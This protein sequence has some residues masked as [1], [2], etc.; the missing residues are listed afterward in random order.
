M[1]GETLCLPP[2]RELSAARQRNLIR[3]LVRQRGWCTPPE[4]RLSAGLRQLLAARAD[5]HPVLAWSNH[6]IRRFR[7]RLYLIETGPVAGLAE[8]H[9]WS[10]EGELLLGGPRGRLR[11]QPT[12]GT[13][14]AARILSGGLQVSFRSGGEAVRSSGDLHHRTLKYLFQKHAIVPWMRDH[15]PLLYVGGELAAV[16]NLWLADWAM[17]GPGEPGAVPVWEAHAAI[18]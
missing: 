3:S 13:G 8:S 6:E 16:A 1:Q 9:V 12:P 18:G 7:E 17:A 4:Q 15:I 2:F 11:L 5:R 14:L 10:G